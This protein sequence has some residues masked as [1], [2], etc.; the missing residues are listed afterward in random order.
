MVPSWW[1]ASEWILLIPWIRIR[2]WSDDMDSSMSTNE[3][4]KLPF[5]KHVEDEAF[6]FV[7]PARIGW[8]QNY[9]HTEFH[10][11]TTVTVQTVQDGTG[12]VLSR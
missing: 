5:P 1:V 2:S 8:N 9:S 4:P 12:L 7:I 3:S 11:M 6:S 10:P